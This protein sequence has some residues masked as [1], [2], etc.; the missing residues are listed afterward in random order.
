[1]K[2]ELKQILKQVSGID[3]I[4][5]GAYNF[6]INGI[7]ELH[8]NSE[9]TEIVKKLDRSGI[10]VVVKANTK[11]ELIHIPT[12]I[13]ESGLDDL[14]YNDFFIG[15]NSEVH[16]LAGCG[17][18]NDGLHATQHSGIHT[19]YVGKNAK[20]KY[21][22]KH[23]GQGVG[24]GNKIISPQTI[25][26]LAEGSTLEIDSAQIEGVDFT[27]RLTKATIG[28]NASLITKEVILTTGNQTAYTDFRIDLNGENSSASIVSRSVA[29][30][31]SKQFFYSVING[32][33]KCQGHSACDAIIMDYA[34][35]KAVPDVTANHVD[36]QLIHEAAIGKIAGEQITKLMSLGLNYEEA[37]QEIV[38]AFL[39]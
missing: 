30:G 25:I 24:T 11:G 33:N 20:V 8:N 17:I 31:Q 39:R 32:N 2:T 5:N 23:Y 29:K 13:D 10:D 4:P 12:L 26:H 37:E 36:A 6:R 1:M 21:E 7:S 19:F 18:H 9:N 16:I 35:V 27:K 15:E 34:T 14:V 28:D 22:E 38:A 3:D